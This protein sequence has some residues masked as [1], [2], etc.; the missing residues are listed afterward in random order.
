MISEQLKKRLMEIIHSKTGWGDPLEPYSERDYLHKLKIVEES[1]N[2]QKLEFIYI[3]DEDNFSQYSK[4]HELK[5]GAVIM[6]GNNIVSVEL[7][8]VST[9]E[10]ANKPPYKPN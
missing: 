9:G 1:E 8:E 5:C 7:E 2:K 4:I 10:A 6:N 3:F